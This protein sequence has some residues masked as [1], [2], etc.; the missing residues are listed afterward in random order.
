MNTLSEIQNWYL[1]QCND[2]WEHGYG[3][4]IGT[5]DNPGWT[6]D[7]DLVG[8]SFEHASFIPSEHGVGSN[9]EPDSND[10][11]SIKVEDK[12]F[13]GRCGPQHLETV[14]RVFLD[15]GKTGA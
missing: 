14:L 5:L 7:I 15:W 2:D 1:S 4:S 3:V 11:W 13:I 10:W 12:K 6:V 9:S 8:T